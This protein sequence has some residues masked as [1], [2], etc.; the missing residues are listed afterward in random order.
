MEDLN[1]LQNMYKVQAQLYQNDSNII[2]KSDKILP[3][4][5][6]ELSLERNDIFHGMVGRSIKIKQVFKAIGNIAVKD[7]PVLITG[8]PGTG[9]GLA[10]QAIHDLSSRSK[11]VKVNINCAAIGNEF[12]ENEFFGYLQDSFVGAIG[13]Y[14]GKLR[15]ADGGILFLDQVEKLSL[16]FQEKLSKVLCSKEVS[17]V[18]SSDIFKINVRIIAS[19]SASI[20]NL[21]EIGNFSRDLYDYINVQSIHIPDLKERRED[22]PI[23]ILFLIFQNIQSKDGYSLYFDEKSM[24]A[25]MNYDWPENIGEMQNIIQRLAVLGTG[26]VVRVED[27]PVKMHDRSESLESFQSIFFVELPAEGINLKE[28]LSFIE[29]SLIVQALE[30]TKGNKNQASKLLSINRTTLIEKIKKKNISLLLK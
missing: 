9:K 14:K 19:S 30:R 17:P 12:L 24:K 2:I 27:L 1:F 3:A 10:A 23:L 5:F 21:V 8:A 16:R 15:I 26:K 6:S 25:L 13:N 22:I 7:L 18:G 11:E 28:S 20:E 4:K 29:T